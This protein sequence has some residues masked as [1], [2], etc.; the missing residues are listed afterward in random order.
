MK[1]FHEE[2]R[3]VLLNWKL[4]LPRSHFGPLQLLRDRQR[5]VTILSGKIDPGCLGEI[6]SLLHNG[7]REEHI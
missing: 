7:G 2:A 5:E 1:P 6:E 3:L 4:R